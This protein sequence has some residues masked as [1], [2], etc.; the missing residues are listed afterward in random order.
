MRG[1]VLK[2]VRLDDRPKTLLAATGLVQTWCG[3]EDGREGEVDSASALAKGEGA[4]ETAGWSKA[5]WL[6]EEP[7]GGGWN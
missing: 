1:D 5:V 4:D 3:S 2:G 6:L 7:R